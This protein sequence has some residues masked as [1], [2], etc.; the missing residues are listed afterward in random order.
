ML[1]MLFCMHKIKLFLNLK[2]VLAKTANGAF[3]V[4]GNFLPRRSGSDAV[5]GIAKC[6]I[7]FITTGTYI[8]HFKKCNYSDTLTDLLASKLPSSS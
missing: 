3:E 6:R 8:F 1:L 5:I 7:V 2:S 4:L